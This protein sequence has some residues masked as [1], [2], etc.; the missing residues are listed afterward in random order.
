VVHTRLARAPR[1][2]A[3]HTVPRR[4]IQQL[5]NAK[6]S[7]EAMGE[8]SELSAG[9]ESAATRPVCGGESA[10]GAALRRRASDAD[11]LLCFLICFYF[12]S[13]STSA[14]LT[15]F[16]AAHSL[17]CARS[18]AHFKL[19]W[20]IRVCCTEQNSAQCCMH[21]AQS[22]KHRAQSTEHSRADDTTN[23]PLRV[24]ALQA[25]CSLLSALHF[26]LAAH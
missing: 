12:C 24:A 13:A 16:C 7:K 18:T 10:H 20:F 11:W 6:L 1:R 9:G 21:K 15:L 2:P 25:L 22:T 4:P 3:P 8:H 23:W 14:L 19:H 17:Q 5:Q 26:L